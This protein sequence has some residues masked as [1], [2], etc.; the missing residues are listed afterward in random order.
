MSRGLAWCRPQFIADRALDVAGDE[1][2]LEI[3][4]EADVDSEE[5]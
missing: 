4:A 1:Q 5:G 2:Y 3:E